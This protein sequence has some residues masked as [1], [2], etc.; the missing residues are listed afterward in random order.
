VEGWV[1]TVTGNNFFV[2]LLFEQLLP[3]GFIRQ[4]L[5]PFSAQFRSKQQ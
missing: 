2:T 1:V 4:V 5:F 3:R